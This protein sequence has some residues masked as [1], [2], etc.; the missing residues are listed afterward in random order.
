MSYQY[1]YCNI[2]EAAVI[3][4][5]DVPWDEGYTIARVIHV[6]ANTH[7]AWIQIKMFDSNSFRN[8]IPYVSRI[9][10]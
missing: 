2:C 4:E 1:V 8:P 10:S 3:A 9:D 5:P 6:S 7:Q